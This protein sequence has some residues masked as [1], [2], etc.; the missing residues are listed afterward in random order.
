M[1]GPWTVTRQSALAAGQAQRATRVHRV[2]GQPDDR[3]GQAPTSTLCRA[4][5]ARAVQCPDRAHLL[6]P[7][8]EH[9]PTGR[10][11]VDLDEAAVV[12]PVEYR[13]DNRFEMKLVVLRDHYCVLRGSRASRRPSPM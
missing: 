4:V 11:R 3:P 10:D 8:P 5:D 2:P 9:Q 6:I 7:A 13:F 12:L 1:T